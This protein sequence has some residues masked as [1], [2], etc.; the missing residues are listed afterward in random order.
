MPSYVTIFVFAILVIFTPSRPIGAAEMSVVDYYKACPAQYFGGQKPSLDY[1]NGAWQTNVGMGM[2]TVD[3]RNGYI[4][5][6]AVGDGEN[7]M[8]FV[9]Y[10]KSD[11][12]PVVAI[13]RYYHAGV[14]PSNEFTS[15]AFYEY[16]DS[17]FTDC[18]RDLLPKI[19]FRVFCAPG[20]ATARLEKIKSFNVQDYIDY[21]FVLPQK[22]TTIV[23]G[24]LMGKLYDHLEKKGKTL[25]P[26]EKEVCEQ[27]MKSINY[28]EG[29]E[30]KW[31]AQKGV[32]AVGKK[33]RRPY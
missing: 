27:F 22:G 7:I 12:T 28:N 9:L 25:L 19:D 14:G 15:L 3:V 26:G 30:L 33:T 8:Q 5:C 29:I 20:Y 18:T 17:K 31:D 16:R 4:E 6:S 32:F 24:I 1:K 11:R 23:T 10:I 13:N 21:R 2:A